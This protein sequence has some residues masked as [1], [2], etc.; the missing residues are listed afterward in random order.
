MLGSKASLS[1]KLFENDHFIVFRIPVR[2]MK[3]YSCQALRL[4]DEEHRVE[5]RRISRFSSPLQS[6]G[7]YIE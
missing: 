3:H 4:G 2:F 5:K 7:Y 6:L 1:W